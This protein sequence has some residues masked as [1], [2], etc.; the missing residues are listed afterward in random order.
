MTI[1]IVTAKLFSAAI[2]IDEQGKIVNA[3][4]HFKKFINLPFNILEDTLRK[5]KYQSLKIEDA[6]ET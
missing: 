2:E 5:Q 6:E 1:K 3:P 4:K